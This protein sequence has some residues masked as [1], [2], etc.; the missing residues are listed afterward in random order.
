MNPIRYF[1]GGTISTVLHG[2]KA[3]CKE[4]ELSYF[5]TPSSQTCA[6]YVQDFLSQNAGY[7]MNPEATESCAYCKF[8]TGDAYAQTLDYHYADRWR[9]WAVLIRWTLNLLA[10]W[11]FT[12]LHRSKLRKWTSR[13]DGGSSAWL[14]SWSLIMTYVYKSSQVPLL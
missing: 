11:L 3:K 9:N 12:W 14:I 2:V 6:E 5:D 7:L 1:L 4:E 10:I 13:R 8:D